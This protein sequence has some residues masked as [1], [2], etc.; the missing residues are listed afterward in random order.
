MATVYQALWCFAAGFVIASRIL[1][2][3]FSINR[4]GNVGRAEQF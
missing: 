4:P 2:P 1:R 3:F